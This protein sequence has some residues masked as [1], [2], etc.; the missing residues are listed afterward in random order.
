MLKEIRVRLLCVF[1]FSFFFPR[2]TSPASSCSH[3]FGIISVLQFYTNL[4]NGCN[5][6]KCPYYT[7]DK[8]CLGKNPYKALS[9]LYPSKITVTIEGTELTGINAEVII[10][11][12]KFLP[13]KEKSPKDPTLT[14]NET[15]KRLN[16]MEYVRIICDAKTV[17]SSLP[18]DQLSCH[19][20]PLPDT[21]NII[22]SSSSH[23][24]KCGPFFLGRQQIRGGF[25]SVT[26]YNSAIAK[27]LALGVCPRSDWDHVKYSIALKVLKAK[28]RQNPKLGELLDS[29]Q[30]AK[31]VE[32]TTRDRWWG[33]G[34]DGSGENMLGK[35]LMAVRESRETGRNEEAS[36]ASGT[37][38]QEL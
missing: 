13:G 11:A 10:Q 14:E 6:A 18:P 1:S 38:V 19:I 30:N 4:K 5:P 33:D 31:L 23:L 15:E 29:T 32:H 2:I 7:K 9:N 37:L 26:M 35:L 25:P 3:F 16:Q 36:S 20:P 27:Y 17:T 34:G 12:A 24:Q 21:H 28:F 8:S 22:I